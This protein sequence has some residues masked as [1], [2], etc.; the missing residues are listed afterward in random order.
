MNNFNSS[1][2]KYPNTDKINT[3][4]R[5]VT[6]KIYYTEIITIVIPEK[7]LKSILHFRL[8]IKNKK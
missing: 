6:H 7:Y 5:C 3:R 8:S 1:L 2:K 4:H